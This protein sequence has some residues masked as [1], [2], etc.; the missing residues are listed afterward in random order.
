[1][2]DNEYGDY[3]IDIDDLFVDELDEVELESRIRKHIN[4][5]IRMRAAETRTP[6]GLE[7]DVPP[8]WQN[9]LATKAKIL[10]SYQEAGW[11]IMWYE[12]HSQGPGE[13]DLL[14]SWIS[15]RDRRFIAK[16]R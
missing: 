2:S 3:D 11:K 14:R 16:E 4:E 13:G 9:L 10:Y 1:M 5:Q 7:I 12:K 6:K 15:I 8:E